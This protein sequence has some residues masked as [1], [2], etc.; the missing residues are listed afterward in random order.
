[1]FVIKKLI[2]DN[3]YIVLLQV[4][5]LDLYMYP[6]NIAFKTSN[7]SLVFQNLIQKSSFSDKN[8]EA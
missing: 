6:S 7:Q 3:V 5:Y 8:P 1:M 2:I 4:I